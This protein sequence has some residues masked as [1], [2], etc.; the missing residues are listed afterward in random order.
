MRFWQKTTLYIWKSV[1]KNGP[2]QGVP[3][4]ELDSC[5]KKLRDYRSLEGCSSRNPWV[6]CKQRLKTVARIG[7]GVTVEKRSDLNLTRRRVGKTCSF[8]LLSHQLIRIARRVEKRPF[9]G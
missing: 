5:V 4:D 2:L 3:K 9:Y 7:A 8:L 1:S 6:G